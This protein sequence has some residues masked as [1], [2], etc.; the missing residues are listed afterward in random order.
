M[1]GLKLFQADDFMVEVS[2]DT[3]TSWTE[4]VATAYEESDEDA[5][6]TQVTAL[7]N[8]RAQ[9]VGQRPVQTVAITMDAAQMSSPT[10]NRL[11]KESEDGNNVQVRVS[12]QPEDIALDHLAN[13]LLAIAARS[14]SDDNAPSA[15]TFSGSALGSGGS[16]Q[17]LAGHALLDEDYQPGVFAIIGDDTSSDPLDNGE[18]ASVVALD[19]KTGDDDEPTAS[20]WR[21]VEVATSPAWNTANQGIAT[22]GDLDADPPT[23][24]GPENAIGAA[25]FALLYPGIRRPAFTAQVTSGG[26]VGIRTG[27][28]A[29]TVFNL[30]PTTRLPALQF[31]LPTKN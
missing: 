30:A 1:A 18:T 13:R 14:G 7:Y 23:F 3:G 31:L 29:A 25:R 17:N 19:S 4:L 21:A 12:V 27:E 15:G 2:F 6:T 24:G 20:L 8:R 22:I 16:A 11:I 10:L 5:P 28:Q 26:A 9:F